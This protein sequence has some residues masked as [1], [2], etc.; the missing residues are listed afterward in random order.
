LLVQAQVQEE[1]ISAT[2]RETE[3][4]LYKNGNGGTLTDT[5]QIAVIHKEPEGRFMTVVGPGTR[6]GLADKAGQTLA[7]DVEPAL[8]MTGLPAALAYHLMPFR[9]RLMLVSFL[10]IAER[11][12]AQVSGGNPPP[13]LQT[14]GLTSITE[15][16][17]H[18]LPC[19]TIQG[20]PNPAFAGFFEDK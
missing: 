13:Q 18:D 4:P 5:R 16:V 3:R 1:R 15:T 20:H 8:N 19:A 2:N 6:Q 17:G 7:Q 9:I 10:E 12:A 11:P 14:T